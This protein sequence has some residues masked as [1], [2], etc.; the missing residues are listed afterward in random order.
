MKSSAIGSELINDACAGAELKCAASSKIRTRPVD[1]DAIPDDEKQNYCDASASQETVVSLNNTNSGSATPSSLHNAGHLNHGTHSMA[2][3]ATTPQRFPSFSAPYFYPL[4]SS[5][6]TSP[7]PMYS[8]SP[9]NSQINQPKHVAPKAITRPNSP[10][11]SLRDGDARVSVTVV[12]PSGGES[13]N[14]G[15]VQKQMQGEGAAGRISNQGPHLE[16]VS[17]QPPN[18]NAYSVGWHSH[19]AFSFNGI[20]PAYPSDASDSPWS[21]PNAPPQPHPLTPTATP[22]L[23]NKP[24]ESAQSSSI[25][26]QPEESSPNENVKKSRV[27][28]AHA[29]LRP[30]VGRRK[31]A[32]GKARLPQPQSLASATHITPKSRGYRPSSV[33][34]LKGKAISPQSSSPPSRISD[35][36]IGHG[37]R[38]SQISDNKKTIN[39]ESTSSEAVKL[40]VSDRAET[41]GPITPTVTG[42]TATEEAIKQQK[43][44]PPFPLPLPSRPGQRLYSMTDLLSGGNLS[45][46]SQTNPGIAMGTG[47]RAGLDMAGRGMMRTPMRNQLSMS[48]DQL[49]TSPLSR[50][51]SPMSSASKGSG[52]PEPLPT[53]MRRGDEPHQ[54]QAPPSFSLSHKD[55]FGTPRLS[56]ISNLSEG[57]HPPST[58]TSASRVVLAPGSSIGSATTKHG[59]RVMTKAHLTPALPGSSSPHIRTVAPKALNGS[60]AAIPPLGGLRAPSLPIAPRTVETK[61]SSNLFSQGGS[62][63]LLPKVIGSPS[64]SNGRPSQLITDVNQHPSKEVTP[65]PL[66]AHTASFVGGLSDHPYPQL[67]HLPPSRGFIPRNMQPLVLRPRPNMGLNASQPTLPVGVLPHTQSHQRDG[68]LN[69]PIGQ[70]PLWDPMGRIPNGFPMGGA[71]CSPQMTPPMFMQWPPQFVTQPLAAPSESLINAPNDSNVTSAKH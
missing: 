6:H 33:A 49:S 1:K 50:I 36:N 23:I 8:K 70:S 62:Q 46:R 56:D 24:K 60:T 53:L 25:V 34:L 65:L 59:Q 55:E 63:L 67:G 15:Q 68:G 20:T 39:K 71:F 66:P 4:Q 54:Q 21:S 7:M 37:R 61:S 48:Q 40:S 18:P 43:Q 64:S 22:Q 57:A 3:P 19:K 17:P 2:P 35:L 5:V 26:A 16:R 44:Q 11:S 52:N 28:T 29:V 42:P 51:S 30:P 32:A 9:S 31:V 13:D 14:Q 27:A 69:P 41:M 10:P 38:E 45:P 47:M 12:A 58:P